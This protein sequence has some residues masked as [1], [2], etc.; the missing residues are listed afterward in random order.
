MDGR[1][2]FGEQV[3]AD[4]DMMTGAG[5][6]GHSHRFAGELF[7]AEVPGRRVREVAG[8]KHRC[9]EPLDAVAIGKLGPDQSGG[10]SGLCAVAREGIGRQRPTE[11]EVCR[12]GT[13]GNRSEPIARFR[14][15]R[16]Q[17]GESPYTPFGIGSV[18]E[19]DQHP[20]ELAGLS[21]NQR[22]LSRFG[23]KADGRQPVAF[24]LRS[25]VEPG[26]EFR[27][28]QSGDRNRALGFVD[29]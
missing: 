22:M 14:Q 28:G 2:I 15:R 1:V 4:D 12:V 5:G 9:G 18:A 19:P 6:L 10:R 8:E 25:L 29:Q 27:L 23:G 16:R 13:A 7:G 3:V 21:G 11:R 20:G 24:A 26:G 17:P